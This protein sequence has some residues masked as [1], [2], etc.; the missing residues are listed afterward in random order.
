MKMK[1]VV[2]LGAGGH[3]RVVAEALRSSGREVAAFLDRERERW[4]SELD[5][6]RVAGG[7]DKLADYPAARFD[8]AVGV[9]GLKDTRRRR[10]VHE[11]AASRGAALPP[12]VAASALVSPSARLGA[13]A[14]VLTH[15]VVHPGASVGEGA[16][17]NTAAVVEHDCVV[18]AHGFVGPGAILCGGASLGEGAFVGAGAVVLP[19][20]SVGA[21]A[22]VAAG[23][24]VRADVPAGAKELGRRARPG[25]RR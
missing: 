16:V 22:L 25:G 1:P 21:G 12:V 8:C 11:F 17:V 2:I 23:A 20:V 4:G 24:V 5:G 19:G 3:G 13:G 10:A 7:D 9:G 6:T 15:A 18:G 14:Q